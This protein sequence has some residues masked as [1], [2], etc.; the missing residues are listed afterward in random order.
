MAA[1][2][3][4]LSTETNKSTGAK[5]RSKLYITLETSARV[6]RAPGPGLLWGPPLGPPLGPGPS[7]GPS[8]GP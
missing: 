1:S 4:Y 3:L 2:H 7:P 8:A 6:A 5:L